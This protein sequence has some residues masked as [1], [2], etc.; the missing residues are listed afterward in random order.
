MLIALLLPAVQ[1]AR[2]AA[3]RMQCS[4]NIRQLALA[5]HNFHDAH[6]RLPTTNRQA[7]LPTPRY[8]HIGALAMLLPFIEQSAVFELIVQNPNYHPGWSADVPENPY[9]NS[10]PAFLCPSEPNRNVA[11][12]GAPRPTNYRVN[13]GDMPI[14]YDRPDAGGTGRGV[15]GGHGVYHR[16]TLQGMPDGTSNTMMFAEGVIGTAENRD[17]LRGGVAVLTP[18]HMTSNWGWDGSGSFRERHIR[19]IEWLALR[20]P[21]GMIIGTT[22][23]SSSMLGRRWGDARSL[24]TGVFTVLPPNSLAV[25]SGDPGS[26]GQMERLTI[27]TAASYHPGGASTV[28]S[29][30]SFRFVSDNVNTGDLN[31]SFQDL[32]PGDR[33]GF[34]TGPT[35][36]GVWGAY[37][38]MGARDPSPTF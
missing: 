26:S 22:Y 21:G 7:A 23:T 28:A 4:N 6:Q 8:T 15:F 14:I 19:P 16:V 38:T 27:A 29:D 24:F 35:P 9:R 34:Y 13:L 5:A 2:E 31:T 33:M 11:T 20:G 25:S 17:Q 37:G 3:R 18:E 36:Y 10:I 12:G 32:M 30:A 1:A